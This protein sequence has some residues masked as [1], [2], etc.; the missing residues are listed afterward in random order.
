MTTP[1]G[2]T[3]PATNTM[4]LGR[5]YGVK[6]DWRCCGMAPEGF[7]AVSGRSGRTKSITMSTGMEEG[8]RK[9]GGTR[10][11]T[12]KNETIFCQ[13]ISFKTGFFKSHHCAKEFTITYLLI[14][15]DSVLHAHT[16]IHHTKL[17]VF[18]F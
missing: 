2:T 12:H 4:L 13:P 10:D 8:S 17:K 1:S 7:P 18:V 3:F 14:Q 6:L 11:S 16:R 9:L 5:S 15:L